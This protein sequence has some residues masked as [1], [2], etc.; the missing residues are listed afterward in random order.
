MENKAEPVLKRRFAELVKQGE[1]LLNKLE[2]N[3]TVDV[4]ERPACLSWLLSAVNLLEVALPSDSRFSQEA[5]RLLPKADETLW[6][7]RIATILG[8]L[9]SAEAEWRNGLINTLELRFVGLA[10]DDFLRHASAFNEAGKKMEAAVLASAVLEDTVKRLCQKHSISAE[11]KSLENLINALK[12]AGTLGKVKAERLKSYAALR[13]KAF[14]ADWD[15]FDQ[16]DLRQMI[17]GLEEVLE[18]H[19]S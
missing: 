8:V 3:E 2:K 10:F 7:E 4:H 16:R 14:H 12:S 13:N 5:R 6:V 11:S 15:S 1:Q 19:F 17:D 18:L 9:K